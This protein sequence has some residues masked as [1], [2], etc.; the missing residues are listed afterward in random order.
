VKF[1]TWLSIATVFILGL[2]VYF[3][4]PEIMQAFE[5][6]A[7]VNLWILALLMPIQIISF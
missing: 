3:A 4:W 7:H 1:R 5:L 2:V 6:L